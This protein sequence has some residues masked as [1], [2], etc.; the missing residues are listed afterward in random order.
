VLSEVA[1]CLYKTTEYYAPEHERRLIWN[2]RDV[3]IAWPNDVTPILSERDKAGS[4]LAVAD[5][6]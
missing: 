3:S 6:Y 2:D 1:D 4:R 5:L